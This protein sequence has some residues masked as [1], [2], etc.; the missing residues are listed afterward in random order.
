[1]E[2]LGTWWTLF[3]AAL[4]GETDDLATGP[5]RRAIPLLAIPM[6]LEMAGEA[7]FALVDV[8]FVGGFGLMGWVESED[9]AAADPDPLADAAPGII[10]HMNADHVDAMLRLA[11]AHAGIEAT[12]A[13]MTSVDR[14]GFN[15]KL[16][17]AE[18]VRGARVGFT[19]EV[20]TPEDTR[21]VLVSMVRALGDAT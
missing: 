3:V 6:A 10:E 2:T 7:L 4:R 13:Q 8:Y 17:T 9:Y 18:R 16:E 5:L 1:M 19:R 14:L 21:A 15:V 11:K 12:G 20:R